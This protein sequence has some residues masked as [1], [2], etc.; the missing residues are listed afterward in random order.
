MSCMRNNTWI[1]ISQRALAGALVAVLALTVVQAQ[2]PP[3][4]PATLDAVIVT[5]NKRVEHVQEVPKQ[6]LVVTPES[7]ARSG[8]TSIRELGSVV[9]SISG[10]P[11]EDE[12]SPAPP[13]RGI[14]SFSISIGVQSQ[15]GVV[16]D[17]VPQPSFS[18]LFKELADVERVEDPPCPGAMPR[19]VSSIL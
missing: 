9:P 16:V 4:A 6:V 11:S 5:A 3:D 17:D 2:T 7:L 8:V 1:W 15:T 14:S 10:T 13:I 18:S 19:E 12:R